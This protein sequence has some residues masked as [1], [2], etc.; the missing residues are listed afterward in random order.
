MGESERETLARALQAA[1]HPPFE[2]RTKEGGCALFLPYGAR[3]LGLFPSPEGPNC[4]YVDP[5]MGDPVQA[6]QALGGAEWVNT[7]GDRT[8]LSPEID[9]CIADFSDPW[10]TYKVPWSMDPGQHAVEFRGDMLRAGVSIQLPIHR[11][12]TSCE[13]VLE[14]TVRLIANPLRRETA[15]RGWLDQVRYVGYELVTTVCLRSVPE[16]SMCTGI[17]NIVALPA[18]GEILVPTLSRSEPR[19]YFG[20]VG[21]N[22]LKVSEGSVHLRIDGA[23]RYKVGLRATSLTGR[24]GYLRRLADG[25]VVLV[26]RNFDVDPS[27]EYVDVP[28]D[29]PDD[30]GYAFE[31]YNDDGYY[32][33]FGELEYH[34]PAIGG[35]TGRTSGEDRSQVWAFHG[36]EGAV[37]AIAEALLGGG[38]L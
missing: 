23:Q 13:I 5:R 21:A 3:V 31:A 12:R 28:W 30:L 36:P 24:A 29:A 33:A 1:E 34:A 11:K 6:R 37:R 20:D 18:P 17:W 19:T 2:L 32:G 26:V 4:Y 14:K 10:G 7:G 35:D 16:P 38:V 22:Y 25:S 27:G 15:A 9:T 8:W